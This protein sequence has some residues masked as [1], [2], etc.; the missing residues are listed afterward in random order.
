MDLVL[1]LG[2]THGHLAAFEGARLVARTNVRW[3]RGESEIDGELAAFLA[4]LGTV[5]A[6]AAVASVNPAARA[7][8]LPLLE[9]RLGLRPLVLGETL[10][11]RLVLDV[12]SP[13]RVGQDRLVN[14]LWAARTFPGRAAVVADLGTALSFAVVDSK[15]VFRGGAIAPGIGTGARA[16]AE[17]TAQLPT[18]D[19]AQVPRALGR[20]TVACIESGL[21]WGAV[22]LVDGLAERFESELGERA[23]VVATGGD[24]A[25]VARG[26]RRIERVVPELTLEGVRLALAEASEGARG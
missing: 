23:V 4:S 11:L 16:L 3:G 13:E 20:S 14:A 24:A 2:N 22:G 8:V 21:Y 25:L 10:T 12:E 17:K 15:G 9:K 26:S 19:L 18:V 1:D 5:P 6:R 7:L